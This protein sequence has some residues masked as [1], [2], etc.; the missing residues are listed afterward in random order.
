MQVLT[1]TL[2]NDYDTLASQ[3]VKLTDWGPDESSN[4]VT[5]SMA[6]YSDA[7]AELLYSKYGRDKILVNPKSL[8]PTNTKASTRF[9]DSIPWY[10]GDRIVHSPGFCTAA[11]NTR[12]QASG[13][14]Y[15]LTAGHCGATGT[16]WKNAN[17]AIFGTTGGSINAEGDIDAAGIAVTNGLPRVFVGTLASTATAPVVGYYTST[18]HV[19][20]LMTVNGSVTGEVRQVTLVDADRCHQFTDVRNCHLSNVAKPGTTIVQ[21]GDSGGPTYQYDSAGDIHALGTYVGFGDNGTMWY[22]DIYY[23]LSRFNLGI[24]TTSGG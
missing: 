24:L 9:N 21:H 4:R 10:G 8:P 22:Q 3:G 7:G 5:I 11:F 20:E 19:G 14:I 17:G 2:E 15:A 18:T 6:S 23:E 1:D 12:G 16:V 13:T